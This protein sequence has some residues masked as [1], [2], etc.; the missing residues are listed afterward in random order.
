MT[1]LS[2]TCPIS[3]ILALFWAW[4]TEKSLPYDILQQTKRV[5][6]AS[7]SILPPEIHH[8]VVGMLEDFPEALR[9][10]NATSWALNDH[11]RRIQFK[12]I[13]VLSVDRLVRL[14]DLLLSRNCTIPTYV[15]GLT[16]EFEPSQV[17]RTIWH[18]SMTVMTALATT[19]DHFQVQHFLCLNSHWAISRHLDW[20]YL[21]AHANIRKFVLHGTYTC[22][23]DIPR[24]LSHLRV[25]ESLTLDASF[26]DE[27][28]GAYILA[29]NSADYA[30][31]SPKLKEI[32]LSP[33]SLVLMR[34]MCSLEEGPE[35]LHLARIRVDGVGEHSHYFHHISLFLEKYG[36]RMAHL[37]VSFDEVWDLYQGAHSFIRLLSTVVP[38][39]ISYCNDLVLGDALRH[40]RHLK[41]LELLLP[42]AYAE[43]ETAEYMEQISIHLQTPGPVVNVRAA[44]DIGVD[45]T[46][47]WEAPYLCPGDD[48]DSVLCEALSKL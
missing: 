1:I 28:H 42:C 23:S 34:W 4:S 47:F 45:E 26:V 8:E 19:L 41:Q 2:S 3:W 14:S 46:E 24:F 36:S 44:Y 30:F 5:K 40:T 35:S 11:A 10:L 38:E 39:L 48:A 31:L 27:S 25:L 12:T 29:S 9:Q 6:H 17:G 21:H 43:D 13:R 22:I 32:S 33:A 7:S 16:I 18:T 15:N 37:Y 20:T